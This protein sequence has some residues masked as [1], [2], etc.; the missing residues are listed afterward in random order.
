MFHAIDAE[1]FINTFSCLVQSL[2]HFQYS[3][4]PFNFIVS[5]VK[6]YID[7]QVAISQPKLTTLKA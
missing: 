2:M 6:T 3:K 4:T 5:H 7:N 1:I